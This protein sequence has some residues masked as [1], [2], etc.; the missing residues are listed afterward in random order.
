MRFGL[1]FT[2]ALALSLVGC[3]D[4]PPARSSDAAVEPDVMAGDAAPAD[5]LTAD[6]AP[7]DALPGDGSVEPDAFV[8]PPGGEPCTT[9]DQCP[10]GD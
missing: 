6:A 5:A 10:F 1:A 8:P 2:G 7:A 4:D 3:S 9:A